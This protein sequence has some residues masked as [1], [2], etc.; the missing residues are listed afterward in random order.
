MESIKNITIISD[1]VIFMDALTDLFNISENI[2]VTSVG[3]DDL[4]FKDPLVNRP[5]LILF[6]SISKSTITL[7]FRNK[8]EEIKESI[9]II[10]IYSGDNNQKNEKNAE[11]NIFKKPIYFPTFLRRIQLQVRD[12]IEK[13]NKEVRI[14]PYLF[15]YPMK[16]LM[17]QGT[18]V[19][20]LTEMEAKILNFLYKSDGMLIKRDVL[21]RE[22]WGYNSE[23]M[24]HTLETHIYRL[25]KKI[26]RHN[27]NQTLLISESGGYRL[28]L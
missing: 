19:V 27:K 2:E 25:R 23:V 20:R 17:S 26:E 10:Y 16:T 13:K 28:N 24:T 14:G 1:K 4:N 22:V 15:S 7:D 12:F 5:D 6:D 9:P 3:V 8:L 21:L 11:I 18:L